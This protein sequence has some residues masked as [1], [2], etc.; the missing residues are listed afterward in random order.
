MLHQNRCKLLI[1]NEMLAAIHHCHEGESYISDTN[2]LESIQISCQNLH[3]SRYQGQILHIAKFQMSKIMFVSEQKEYFTMTSICNNKEM[4]DSTYNLNA[5]QQYL[6]ILQLIPCPRIWVCSE[7]N[8]IIGVLW[9]SCYQFF[10]RH[11]N[12]PTN[13]I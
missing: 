4:K 5:Y 2:Y 8:T 7:L 12:E 10:V 3:H 13:Q 6:I 9:F 1:H 11:I